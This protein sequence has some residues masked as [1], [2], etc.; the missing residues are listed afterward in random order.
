MMWFFKYLM[1]NLEIAK[2]IISAIIEEEV[3]TLKFKEQEITP[4]SDK[5]LP[6][7]QNEQIGYRPDFIAKIKQKEGNC[8]HMTIS[9]QNSMHYLL[10][11]IFITYT[12]TGL[13]GI[14]RE[15]NN[16]ETQTSVRT[17]TLTK[18]AAAHDDDG[19]YIFKNPRNL[20]LTKSGEL[21]L[22]DNG[23]VIKFSPDG[24]FSKVI[25][26]KGQGPKEATYLFQLIIR[27]ENQLIVNTGIMRKL[28]ILDL[29]GNLISE[30]M[31]RV[32]PK[33]DNRGLSFSESA[34]I[35]IGNH[36]N[37]G[38]IAIPSGT[39]KYSDTSKG[40]FI[41][42]QVRL[43]SNKNQWKRKLFEIPVPATKIKTPMGNYSIQNIL[44]K[45]TCG[46]GYIF[47]TN[48]FR[49]GIKRY[50][51]RKN[52][53]EPILKR[54][55]TPVYIPES[56]AKKYTFGDVLHVDHK[57]KFS[58][59]KANEKKTFPDIQKMFV[60]GQNLWA[61]T[62]TVDKE[63]GVLVDVFNHEGRYTDHFYLKLPANIDLRTVYSTP[64]DIK[65][66]YMVVTETDR[67]GHY[68]VNKY[69]ISDPAN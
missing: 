32:K 65:G 33:T 64:I 42:K 34:F 40:Y 1:S 31:N 19:N 15:S 43:L 67:D 6:P 36:P 66:Q 63:K 39:E 27:N 61:V 45:F 57:G 69:K 21:F 5:T 16:P 3:L 48:S 56:D 12:C 26:N 62:S 50:N 4:A 2:G 37:S 17:L 38:F 30:H 11:F 51:I 52:T 58:K 13:L 44:I 60:I 25:V 68:V 47:F 41:K 8:K 59:H 23:K 18:I 35:I 53:F 49:Y 20:A 46:N 29:E 9:L 7:G 24:K 22:T 10:T 54:D 55:Y 28:I 14:P